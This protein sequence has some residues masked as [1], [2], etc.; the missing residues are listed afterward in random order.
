MKK[1]SK[2]S[3]AALLTMAW[4]QATGAGEGENARDIAF[5][6]V[7][8]DELYRRGVLNK[9]DLTHDSINVASLTEDDLDTFNTLFH[10]PGEPTFEDSFVL[11]TLGIDRFK[12]RQEVC[13]CSGACVDCEA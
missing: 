1:I 7:L 3:N 10:E 5:R 8:I 13:G 12:T 9:P 6:Q 11:A 4:F 2:L